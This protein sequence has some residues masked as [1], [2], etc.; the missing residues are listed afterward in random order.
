MVGISVHHHAHRHAGEVVGHGPVLERRGHVHEVPQLVRIARHQHRRGVGQPGQV[1][2]RVRPRRLRLHEA[3]HRLLRG[4][5]HLQVDARPEAGDG[6][7]VAHVHGLG[8][9]VVADRGEA[10]RHRLALAQD[11]DGEVALVH[12]DDVGVLAREVLA[13]RV[14][15]VAD[16]VD[17][18]AADQMVRVADYLDAAAVASEVE[19]LAAPSALLDYL[20]ADCPRPV[21]DLSHSSQPDYPAIS[22]NEKYR[23]G[24][25]V[26]E[27]GMSLCPTTFALG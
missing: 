5:H 6:D 20:V 19:G 13:G 26:A 12:L 2:R 23:P 21:Y 25:A 24:Q 16:G 4:Q 17:P 18:E 22:L 7:G 3:Y 15:P 14:L 11:G 10:H 27:C 9:A 1:Q 8:L